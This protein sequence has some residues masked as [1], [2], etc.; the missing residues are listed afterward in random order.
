MLRPM[1][2]NILPLDFRKRMRYRVSVQYCQVA[3]KML[4]MFLEVGPNADDDGPADLKLKHL[5][6][7]RDSN[8]LEKL[9]SQ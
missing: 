9:L 8:M 6:W 7:I 2:S 3:S 4:T 5:A 1:L